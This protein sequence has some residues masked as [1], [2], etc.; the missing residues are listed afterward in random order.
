MERGA[1]GHPVRFALRAADTASAPVRLQVLGRALAGRP[2]PGEVASG[3]AVVIA[4]GAAMPTGA[5]AVVPV[6]M[7][8][9]DGETAIIDRAVEPGGHVRAAGE[10]LLAGRL[11]L[12]AGTILGPGQLAAAAA[13]GRDRL[14]AHPRPIVSVASIRDELQIRVADVARLLGAGGL[15]PLRD[16]VV[17]RGAGAGP[18]APQPARR[19]GSP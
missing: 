1:S 7:A 10:D 3:A 5:D 6:E 13:M 8:E 9:L 2:F 16:G 12:S 11:V 17:P 14:V 19:P 4:T 15:R 18:E